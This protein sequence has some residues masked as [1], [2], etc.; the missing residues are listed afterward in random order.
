M[1]RQVNPNL[2]GETRTRTVHHHQLC[3]SLTSRVKVRQI[4]T[5][6]PKIISR[7]RVV[8]LN[9]SSNESL[10]SKKNLR[11]ISR[12]SK[13]LETTPIATF[14]KAVKSC[15]KKNV[16]SACQLRSPP[17]SLSWILK[18]HVLYSAPLTLPN[19]IWLILR[20]PLQQRPKEVSTTIIR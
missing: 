12:L 3:I 8:T 15:S 18:P 9:C 4:T 6:R 13:C 19:R 10:I 1:C 7:G 17:R 11:R 2:S 5:A 16:P 14:S 20:S